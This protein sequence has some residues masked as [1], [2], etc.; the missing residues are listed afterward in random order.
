MLVLATVTAA[1]AQPTAT[2]TGTVT[3]AQGGVLPGATVVAV[4]GP[5]GVST[6]AVTR[7]DGQYTLSG[8]RPGA[9]RVT[10]RCRASAMREPRE[11]TFD[12]GQERQ[13]DFQLQIAT[14]TEELT[15][16]AGTALARDE[17]RAVAQHHRRRV[18]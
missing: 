6:Q 10:S 18:G 13:L 4:Y 17:K 11:T 16:R 14:M 8:L 9:Y 3:D 1:N 7:A 15:V 12:A 2:L 5:T